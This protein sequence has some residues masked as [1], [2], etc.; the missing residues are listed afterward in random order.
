MR[1]EKK[2]ETILGCSFC[3]SSEGEV[4]FLVEGDKAYI[5]DICV[6]R[7]TDI[8]KDNLHKNIYGLTF[9]LQKPVDLSLIHI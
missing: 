4:D 3:S 8:V 6:A 5:C 9:N 7:A 1:K 2:E